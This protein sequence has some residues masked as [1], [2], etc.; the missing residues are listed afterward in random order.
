M[1]DQNTPSFLQT[2]AQMIVVSSTHHDF[3]P[4]AAVIFVN[5]EL[6]TRDKPMIRYYR[7]PYHAM[8]VIRLIIIS[9]PETIRARFTADLMLIMIF[10]AA[11]DDY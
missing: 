3:T 2:I 8:L 4:V 9:K 6:Y 5:R 7:V 11:N 1:I 10:S